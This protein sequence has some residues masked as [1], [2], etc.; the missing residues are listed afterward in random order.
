MAEQ[1][2]ARCHRG[3]QQRQ[4]NDRLYGGVET[5]MQRPSLNASA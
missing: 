5:T 3:Q 2:P 4:I 1:P